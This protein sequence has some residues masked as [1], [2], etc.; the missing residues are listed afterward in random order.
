MKIRGTEL[1]LKIR[2]DPC[3]FDNH[4]CFVKKRSTVINLFHFTSFLFF[5]KR[6]Q[7]KIVSLLN[8]ARPW[9]NCV[10]KHYF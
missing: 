10:I 6:E 3:I 9:T 2:V 5:E 1:R 7:V 8:S 4:H